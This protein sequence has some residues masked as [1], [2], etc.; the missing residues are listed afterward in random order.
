M[1]KDKVQAVIDW[2]V[3]KNL[4]QLRGFL[5][6]IDYYRRFIK[7]YDAPST[8]LL[9]K[10]SFLCDDIATTTFQFLKTAVTQAQVLALLNLSRTKFSDK[11]TIQ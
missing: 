10:D 7:G 8:N 1:D 2:P 4:K 9:T 3:P 11:I 6:L 5:R